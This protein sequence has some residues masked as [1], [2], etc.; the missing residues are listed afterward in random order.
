MVINH[1]FELSM[2]LDT[3]HFQQV[4]T[5]AC[6][7]SY[8]K[9]VDDECID[10]SLMEKGIMVSFR[11]SRYKK[12]IRLL[13][14]A[15]LIVDDGN[16]TDKLI[17]KLDKRITEYFG[18]KYT[19]NDF[20]LSGMT[21]TVDID[22]GS[23][24]SVSDYLKVLRRVGRVKGFFP[25]DYEFLDGVD[26]LCLSGRSNDIDFLLYDLSAAVMSQRRNADTGRKLLKSMSS[27]VGSI[28]R[29]HA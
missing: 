26:N 14:N 4:F 10:T 29:T 15:S 5:R 21:L 27:Q 8:L 25:V 13:A 17:R 6:E 20:T 24:V 1:T 2:T 16:D 3:D 12:K 28:I 22:V 18:H 23:R 11:D 19:L 7:G 9:E